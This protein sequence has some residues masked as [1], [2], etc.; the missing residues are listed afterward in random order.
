MHSLIHHLPLS[1]PILEMLNLGLV[2]MEWKGKYLL[3]C[4]IVRY[5][6]NET[7]HS[8]ILSSIPWCQSQPNCWYQFSYYFFIFF[9]VNNLR[10]ILLLF[11]SLAWEVGVFRPPPTPPHTHTK[12]CIIIQQYSCKGALSFQLVDHHYG[13]PLSIMVHFTLCKCFTFLVHTLTP[14]LSVIVKDI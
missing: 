4:P 6:G 11:S 3:L 9:E 8:I 10:R 2:F 1:L 13:I 7:T 12:S 5:I 14:T